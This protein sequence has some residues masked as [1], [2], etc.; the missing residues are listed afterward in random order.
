MGINP[1]TGLITGTSDGKRGTV[2]VSVT[3]TK[4]R[5]L[6][7]DENAVVWGNEYENSETYE[8]VGPVTTA[9]HRRWEQERV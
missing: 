8:S 5:R 9:V 4:E 7:Q 1:E 6:V 2:I 3:L